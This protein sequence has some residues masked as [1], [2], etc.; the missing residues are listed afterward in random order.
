MHR[1][2]RA[3]TTFRSALTII[4]TSVSCVGLTAGKSFCLSVSDLGL[5]LTY[6]DDFGL[7]QFSLH[8]SHGVSFSGV[9]GKKQK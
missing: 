2:R 5:L 3:T 6:Q 8:F 9:L 1:A 7:I 4:K